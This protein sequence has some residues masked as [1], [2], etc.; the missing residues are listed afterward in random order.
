[1]TDQEY[2]AR[3]EETKK[4]V[5]PAT[6]VC[7]H[8]DEP[9]IVDGRIDHPSWMRAEWTPLFGHIED[10][11]IIP[12]WA[13]RAKML[14]DDRYF[15]VGVDMECPDVWGTI[16][17]RDEHVYAYDPDF[18]VFIDPDGDGEEYMEFGMNALNCVYDFLLHKPY[19]RSG[20]ETRDIAWN[21]EGL[22]S[23]VQING[24]LNASWTVDKGWSAV[25]AFDYSSMMAQ[26]PKCNF[27]PKDG[28]V[29]RVNLS[30]LVRDRANTWT[31]KDWT[32]SRVGIYSMHVPE[33][34][35][36]VQFS[37]RPV[38]SARVPFMASTW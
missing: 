8:V 35:G 34:Y 18:E 9:F 33:L 14:W 1:M 21:W 37:D 7:H 23:A 16:T 30:R 22:R 28:D 36:F 19:D 24:T 20:G 17:T 38:G 11:D 3:V 6:Y 2:F 15:Y 25:I 29:W 12:E 10:P 26:A 4:K 31:G 13:T 32:W 5:R 27:P